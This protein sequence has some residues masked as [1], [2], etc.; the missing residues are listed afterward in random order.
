MTAFTM[1][2]LNLCPPGNKDP[3]VR[4]KKKAYVVCIAKY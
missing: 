4:K 2:T 3:S 1:D